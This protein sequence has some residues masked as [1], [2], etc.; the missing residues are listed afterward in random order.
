M[1]N[2]IFNGTS[3]N[4]DI[5]EALNIAIQAAKEGLTSSYVEWNIQDISGKYGG[6]VLQT[7]ISVSIK[8]DAGPK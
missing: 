1:S 7:E 6:T 5:T 8:A 2:D 4:G 3:K